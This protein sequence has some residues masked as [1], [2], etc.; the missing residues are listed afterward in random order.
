MYRL[1][2]IIKIIFDKDDNKHVKILY[3]ISMLVKTPTALKK[4]KPVVI[5]NAGLNN[6]EPRFG[7]LSNNNYPGSF[8]E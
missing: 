8:W 4:T 3:R 7:K 2:K 5:L 1:S 6:Q